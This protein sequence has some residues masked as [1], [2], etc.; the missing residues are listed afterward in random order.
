[1]SKYR[2]I[3]AAEDAIKRLGIDCDRDTKVTFYR[4]RGVTTAGQR[5]QGQVGSMN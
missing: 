2:A 1:M 4:G 3:S 5:L